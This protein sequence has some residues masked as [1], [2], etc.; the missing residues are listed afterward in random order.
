M[1][2]ACI[3]LEILKAQELFFCDIY[4]FVM[5]LIR[6]VRYERVY[7]PLCKVAH[8]PSNIH[9]NDMCTIHGTRKPFHIQRTNC[10]QNS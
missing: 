4:T 6:P 1:D 7:L 3:S 8:K 9:G 10:V 2:T 5:E